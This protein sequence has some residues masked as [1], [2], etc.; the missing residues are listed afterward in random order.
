MARHDSGR[1][2]ARPDPQDVEARILR[3]EASTRW[4]A[5]R[6]PAAP[7]PAIPRPPLQLA[8]GSPPQGQMGGLAGAVQCGAQS[9]NPQ[10]KPYEEGHPE[11]GSRSQKRVLHWG[12]PEDGEEGRQPRLRARPLVSGGGQ[13]MHQATGS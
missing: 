1:V 6:G 9:L 11:D 12:R 8:E 3:R 13:Q 2:H 10:K 5:G 7:C 4:G